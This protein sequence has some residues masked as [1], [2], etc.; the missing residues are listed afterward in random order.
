MSEYESLPSITNLATGLGERS[1]RSLVLAMVFDGTARL[2]VVVGRDETRELVPAPDP[3]D[4]GLIVDAVELVLN[5]GLGVEPDPEV[6]AADR[7]G[8]MVFGRNRVFRLPPMALTTPCNAVEAL[9]FPLRLVAVRPGR[10]VSRL[11]LNSESL[12]MTS[13]LSKSSSSSAGCSP[14]S[15]PGASRCNCKL[16]EGKAADDAE[17]W[18][19]RPFFLSRIFTRSRGRNESGR[20]RPSTSFS[21]LSSSGSSSTSKSS[22]SVVKSVL[23][24][25]LA[26]PLR[27]PFLVARRSDSDVKANESEVVAV[28]ASEAHSDDMVEMIVALDARCARGC[29]E[30]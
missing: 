16:V 19:K 13:P 7:G 18:A 3:D 29:R 24:E 17:D 14:L 12:S 8:D 25:E 5:D 10:S 4:K 1:S 11:G 9:P 27:P 26:P 28:V 30:R 2:A 15:P 21:S 6:E 23:G 20:T 22:S